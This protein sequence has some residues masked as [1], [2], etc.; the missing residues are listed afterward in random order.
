MKT[1]MTLATAIAT[2]GLFGGTAEAASDFHIDELAA[3]LQRQTAQLTYEIEHQFRFSPSYRHL[4]KDA[5]EM[6]ELAAHIHD[7]AHFDG[8]RVHIAD[9]VRK[10]D[11]LYHH[12]EG[13]V[14]S[15]E[16]RAY[17]HARVHRHGYH[18]FENRVQLA[19][20]RHLQRLMSRI[21]STLHHLRDDVQPRRVPVIY[22]YRSRPNR[23]VF[24]PRSP[25]INL[26][27]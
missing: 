13:L 19:D 18:G 4:L 12:V 20:I 2:L 22:E 26:R 21:S 8:N 25:V 6:E 14:D 16:R 7:V 3:R 9:D 24:L 5:R 23:G 11:R 1:M 15:M 27:F 17:R 10:L